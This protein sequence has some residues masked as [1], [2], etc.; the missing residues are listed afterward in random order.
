[1]RKYEYG[2]LEYIS[3]ISDRPQL[4]FALQFISGSRCCSAK[5]FLRF[6]WFLVFPV[7]I[8]FLSK[9]LGSRNELCSV[10]SPPPTQSRKTRIQC[11]IANSMWDMYR[12]YYAER[13][14]R[15][16][17]T[18]KCTSCFRHGIK[19]GGLTRT[20]FYQNFSITLSFAKISKN[21]LYI[22]LPLQFW[23]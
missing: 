8:I 15:C 4:T 18:Y 3:E 20:N 6:T 1:M 11:A 2:I 12:T 23:R 13:T 19:R 14:V 17:K 22:S 5:E 21:I 16:S 9:N 10:C 7:E